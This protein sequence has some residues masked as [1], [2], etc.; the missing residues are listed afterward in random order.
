MN[1]QLQHSQ[2]GNSSGRWLK[3]RGMNTICRLYTIKKD[4]I[5]HSS[6]K[7]DVFSSVIWINHFYLFWTSNKLELS[8]FHIQS[9]W[10]IIHKD[11]L[12]HKLYLYRCG[13]LP[14]STPLSCTVR[15]GWMASVV[16]MSRAF[17]CFVEVCW[18]FMIHGC[19]C[20]ILTECKTERW[21]FSQKSLHII[22]MKCNRCDVK[23]NG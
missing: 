23:F 8:H 7:R 21:K 17:V 18:I 4:S 15:N 2:P 5:K 16:C 3:M 9:C 1:G 20:T 10:F 14:E 22:Y 6:Q 13:G 12:Y 19:S 11:K